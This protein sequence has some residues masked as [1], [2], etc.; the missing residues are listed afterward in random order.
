MIM[1]SVLVFI[2][3]INTQKNEEQATAIEVVKVNC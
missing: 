2:A 3:G 1:I